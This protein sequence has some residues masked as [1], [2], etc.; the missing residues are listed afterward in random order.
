[1]RFR[2]LTRAYAVTLTFFSVFV[3]VIAIAQDQST[4]LNSADSV[5]PGDNLSVENIPP[6]PVSVAE[7]AN[8]YGEFRT[9]SLFGWHP[10]R[11]EMLIGTRF[12]DVPQVHMVRTPGGAR[13]QLTFFPDRIQGAFF[14]AT[15]GDYFVFQKDV[16]GGEWY[17]Y[18][19][20][21][22]STGEI[23]LLT[24]GKSR[25]LGAIFAHKG[26][27][28]VYTSTRRSGKDTDLWTW[29]PPTR[30]PTACC[31]S[32]KEVDGAPQIGHLMTRPFCWRKRFQLIRA[33][34]GW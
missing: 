24:D 5:R 2:L 26:S 1:M 22:F 30:S 23:T 34:C 7:K 20:Y 18:Y 19:R 3:G 27:R 6:I 13:T 28:F 25:N 33:I 17:Q 32:S 16:G 4:K 11:R 21:D 8:R 31:F 9:A 15:S 10:T 29:M 12:G 14:Q